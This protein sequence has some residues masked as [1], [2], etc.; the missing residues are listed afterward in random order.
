MSN[1]NIA[2]FYAAIVY[3]IFGCFAGIVSF[4]FLYFLYEMLNH[5]E[6]K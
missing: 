5:L 3:F 6:N 4:L 2:L 1:M